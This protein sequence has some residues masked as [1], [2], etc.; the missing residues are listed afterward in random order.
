MASSHTFTGTSTG[1]SL[2]TAANWDNNT[3]FAADDV[4]FFTSF[5]T[6][7][8]THAAGLTG[9]A[10]MTLHVKAGYTG[11][12]GV[13]SSGIVAAAPILIGAP[14]APGTNSSAATNITSLYLGQSEGGS[15]GNGSPLFML[16]NGVGVA[17]GSNAASLFIRV[18]K[19]GVAANNYPP[20]TFTGT[21]LRC[22]S[23]GGEVGFAVRPGDVANLLSLHMNTPPSSSAPIVRLGRGCS[24]PE[25]TGTNAMTIEAGTC[26]N[27]ST[28]TAVLVTVSGAGASY[29]AEPDCTGAHT[30][31]L[32]REGGNVLYSGTGTVTNWTV[33]ANATLRITDGQLRSIGTI[34]AH[35]GSV[36]DID[37]GN[38][39]SFSG[40][41][42][43]NCP[44]GVGT[45]TLKA[46]AGLGITLG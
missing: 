9:L 23:Y 25:G 31:I 46:P 2:L 20:A 43:I 29:V 8:V 33:R 34:N 18:Y 7:S 28:A 38:A 11:S 15:G 45:I 22:W 40:G 5:G 17:A 6:G 13:E 16:G 39:S 42:T 3:A 1:L 41:V 4:A 10:G 24:L 26:Y 19:T 30:N 12:W 27:R 32:I 21:N 44:D 14:V 37:N 35:A 36:I